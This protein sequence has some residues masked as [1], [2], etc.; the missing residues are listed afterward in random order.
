[1]SFT[2]YNK[3]KF[4]AS[5][6]SAH[7]CWIGQSVGVVAFVPVSSTSKKGLSLHRTHPKQKNH[8]NRH[9]LY[10]DFREKRHSL[11]FTAPY[12]FPWHIETYVRHCVKWLYYNRLSLVLQHKAYCSIASLPGSISISL[13]MTIFP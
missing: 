9:L 1:M 12:F 4:Y 6:N 8:A 10:H 5:S 7:T 13:N 2:T 3:I 11:N